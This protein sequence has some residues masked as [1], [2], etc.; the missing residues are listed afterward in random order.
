MT[1]QEKYADKIAKLLRKAES[2][3]A[4]EADALIAKAQELMVTYAIDQAMIDAARGVNAKAAEK[5]IEKIIEYTGIFQYQLMSLGYAITTQNA[6]RAF[7]FARDARVVIEDDKRVKKPKMHILTVVG[8]ESD[9]ER[10]TLLEA[11]IQVQCAA[12]LAS[13]WKTVDASW[14]SPMQKFKERRQ[15]IMSFTS[16]VR[17][18]LAAAAEQGHQEA[19][20]NEQ[21]RAGTT[22]DVA[23]SSVALVLRS[24]QDNVNDWVD[25]KYGQM[26]LSYSRVHSGGASAHVAGATAGTRANLGNP[27]LGGR[28]SIGR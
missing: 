20:K 3:T 19:V 22:A 8:Y 2:T 14:M 16:A 17:E 26:R 24:R 5:I 6:C 28:R 1:G 23:S 10:A 7:Y 27:S 4:E 12:A 18:R 13:W 11:S 25:D 21:E 9:I 15:F